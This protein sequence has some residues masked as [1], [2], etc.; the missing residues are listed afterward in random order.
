MGST[1]T[2]VNLDNASK[3]RVKRETE[4]LIQM[5]SAFQLTEADYLEVAKV[6]WASLDTPIS[7]SCAL[8]LKYQEYEQL[9]TRTVR[10][11]DYC[12]VPLVSSWCSPLQFRDDYLAVSVLAKWPNFEHADLDPVG[13]CE[14]ADLAAEIHCRK[15]NERLARVRFSP[16]GDEAAYL[17]LMFR[18]Q[19]DISRVLGAFHPTE[20]L[21]ACRF[22]PGK[23]SA[24]TGT[25]DYEKLL[26]QP[27]VTADFAA[28]GAALLAESTPWLEAVSGVAPDVFSHE[29]GEEE[30]VY[31]FDMTLE[32]GDRNRMVPKNAKTMRGIRPQPGLNVFAQL[33][34]GEMIRHRLRLNGLDLDNQT[35]N[36]HLAQKGSLRGSTLVT[37]DLKGASGHI[38][39]RLPP[40]LLETANP[41]W[42]HA[43]QLTRTTRML[44]HGASDEAAKSDAAWVPMESFSAMGNGYTFELETLIFWAA[45]RACRQKVQDDAPYR[46]YG[47]DIICGCKTADLLLPF[48]DFLGF[49]LNLKKTF[50]EGPFR[51][52]CG[53]DWW[54][55]TN[56]RPIFFSVTAEE[57]H[58]DNE[59]GTSILRWLQT[60]N[61]IRRLARAR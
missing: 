22:G 6:M 17:H 60:C 53:A 54:D 55:G 33:G 4:A 15:T 57:I 11:Q 7:L 52:S 9:V 5:G 35:P 56:V 45:V 1:E 48:L 42:L 44:P 30:M 23:A 27:S 38:A 25:I 21:E 32:P 49:P 20:W 51:E 39:R 16:R 34:I 24:Q 29:C 36:Q 19:A 59:N 61:A 50:L 14:G 41:G 8:L 46:V 18:M 31:R 2:S 47:D 26:S 28:L 10:P 13:A 58:E 3:R 40:F 37:V 43:M 12:D